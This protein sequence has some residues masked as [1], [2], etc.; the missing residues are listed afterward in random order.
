[1]ID[2]TEL[3]QDGDAFELLMRELLS[4]RGLEVYWTG[5]GPDGG[6]DLICSERM[7]GNFDVS[8]KRWVVQ[9]KHNA[10]SRSAVSCSDIDS[11]ENICDAN[12]ADGYL[13]ACTTYPSSKLMTMLHDINKRGKISV[14]VWDC[15]Q[16]EKELQLPQNW[17]IANTFFPISM[18]KKGIQVSYIST[19]FWYLSFK[20]FAFYLSARITANY[21]YFIEYIEKC[22][23][24][25]HERNK[26]LPEGFKIRVRGIYVDDKNTVFYVYVDYMIPETSSEEIVE[27]S[28]DILK[29]YAWDENNID[30]ICF[31]YDIAVVHFFPYSDHFDPDSRDYYEPY[32]EIMK[33]GVERNVNRPILSTAQYDYDYTEEFVDG[34]FRNLCDLFKKI[35]FVRYLNSG[36]AKIE[37]INS[38][39][40]I[41]MVSTIEDDVPQ[42][43][44]K[45]FHAEIRFE[46]KS[47]ED[48]KKLSKLLAEWPNGATE[49]MELKRNFIIMP[50]E[51]IEVD[52]DE[53]IYTISFTISSASYSDKFQF[54][55][56]INLY[57]REIAAI[58]ENQLKELA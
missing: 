52:E 54:R 57:F 22:L 7:I 18:K 50:G 25:L 51:G 38:Y 48:F 11:I 23:D 28:E 6:K 19:N 35:P 2:F 10:H 14:Q 46:I 31:M 12:E 20:G 3:P 5:R 13:L 49:R 56:M 53:S 4:H 21:V 41:R 47:D 43:I 27:E 17:D 55:K 15:I 16:I 39:N 37:K 33:S 29:K 32:I 40:G 9:C 24:D 45:F 26:S 8:V 36:N 44:G 30:G 1:M 34:D 58:L 42:G